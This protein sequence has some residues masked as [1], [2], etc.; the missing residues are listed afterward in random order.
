[1][2]HPVFTTSGYMTPMPMAPAPTI[3]MAT[4]QPILA[5]MSS[6]QPTGTPVL[7]NNAPATFMPT[8]PLPTTCVTP[9][10]PCVPPVAVG[11]TPATSAPPVIPS[12]V[13]GPSHQLPRFDPSQDASIRTFLT[14]FER[15][16]AAYRLSPTEWAAQVGPCLHGLAS[17]FYG[18]HMMRNPQCPWPHLRDALL[19]R[20]EDV[21]YVLRTKQKYLLFTQ[22]DGQATEDY[23]QQLMALAEALPDEHKPHKTMEQLVEPIVDG[24]STPLQN[25]VRRRSPDGRFTGDVTE[26]RKVLHKLEASTSLTQS[27]RAALSQPQTDIH[28]QVQYL[29]SLIEQ[30]AASQVSVVPPTQQPVRQAPQYRPRQNSTHRAPPN[31]QRPSPRPCPRCDGAHRVSQCRA[32][33][34]I[35]PPSGPCRICQGA[36]WRMDCPQQSQANVTSVTTEETTQDSVLTISPLQ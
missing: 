28:K 29:T 35:R 7:A 27:S 10:Q 24:L 19:R 15:T 25:A 32:A 18:Q 17:V 26:L 9:T 36:H 20:F 4:D 2:G 13:V 16:M 30:V 3:T 1:M 14:Q 5:P 33:T 12:V 31:Q 23:L 11:L 6:V 21:S 8:G 22:T 34:A